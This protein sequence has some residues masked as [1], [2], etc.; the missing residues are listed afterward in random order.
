M[1]VSFESKYKQ[2]F[3]CCNCNH[4]NPRG[5]MSGVV[6]FGYAYVSFKCR[7]CGLVND[8]ELKNATV[9]NKTRTINKI[10]YRFKTYMKQLKTKGNKDGKRKL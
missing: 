4:T 9:K 5:L 10:K 1:N 3:V 7:L 6:K 8:A 2:L